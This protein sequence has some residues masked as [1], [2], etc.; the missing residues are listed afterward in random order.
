MRTLERP[1]AER[2]R[3]IA[4]RLHVAVID[5]RDPFPPGDPEAI[6]SC[7]PWVRLRRGANEFSGRRRRLRIAHG[8]E[9]AIVLARVR[10]FPG[11]PEGAD[12]VVPAEDS[13]GEICPIAVADRETNTL[14]LLIDVGRAQLGATSATD[15]VSVVADALLERP[16]RALLLSEVASLVGTGVATRVQSLL[17][18]R[19]TGRKE[20]SRR[21]AE[22]LRRV[23]PLPPALAR[24]LATLEELLA[25][26]APPDDA[27]SARTMEET[28]RLQ[29]LVESRAVGGLRILEGGIAG[30]LSPRSH[31]P[32]TYLPAIGFGLNV[33]PAPYG[34]MLRLWDHE[35]GSDSD[36]HAVCLGQAIDV[37]ARQ[38]D[39][40]DLSGL[41]DTVLNFVETNRVFERP[42]GGW[43]IADRLEDMF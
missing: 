16:L 37:L 24:R 6:A 19:R 3:R 22:F 35:A 28:A 11:A 8:G 25:Q 2:L 42:Y 12:W 34:L 21:E 43:S 10:T 32:D 29:S 4:A 39:A 15:G 7:V 9:W 5:G 27:T 41:V 36:G 23:A 13:R 20:A 30:I 17:A 18:R 26:P 31:E 33:I 40:G 14:H 38:T 1:L